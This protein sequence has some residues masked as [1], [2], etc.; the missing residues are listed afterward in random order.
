M[1]W[2]LLGRHRA[3][4][5]VTALQAACAAY[6]VYDILGDMRRGTLH[7]AIEGAVLL[8]LVLGSLFG[9]REL[10]R[11][12][13]RNRR[14]ED[15]MRAASGAFL[16]LL[17]ESF[18]TWSLTPSERDVAL[19]SIKGLSIAEIAEL[20]QTRVG[21]VKAQ[22]AAVYRKAGVGGRA[23]LLSHFIEDLMS[24]LTLGPTQESAQAS[25]SVQI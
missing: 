16:E 12:L 22:C 24:G 20:R 23:E 11:A 21:T 18:L 10:S 6:F 4:V 17:E 5:V 8:A 13:E 1:D 7:P 14:M 15:G 3:L 19:L 25:E 9:L 2:K